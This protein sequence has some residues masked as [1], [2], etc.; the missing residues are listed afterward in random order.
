MA[1]S[2]FSYLLACLL[3][4]GCGSGSSSN[5]SVTSAAQVYPAQPLPQKF[6][7]STVMVS[8]YSNSSAKG[9]IKYVHDKA[10]LTQTR[11]LQGVNLILDWRDIEPSK[12]VFDFETIDA[13]I[14]EVKS[15]N[16]ILILRIYVNV[17]WNWQA[18][19]DWVMPDNTYLSSDPNSSN[20][21]I[22]ILPWDSKY[23][24]ALE[25]FQQQLSNHFFETKIQPDAMQITIGGLYGEQVLNDYS[26][27]SGGFNG[28]T[29][30]DKLMQA[31]YNHVDIY[32]RTLA[33]AVQDHIA[34]VNSLWPSAPVREDYVGV[35]A[36]DAG[37]S[38]IQSNA[39]ACFLESESYGP[40]TMKMLSRFKGGNAKIFLEDESGHW[41][42]PKVGKVSSL[43][44]RV[45]LMKNLQSTYNFYFD[46][47]SINADHDLDDIDGISAL[48]IMLGL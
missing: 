38:W 30:F 48:K 43:N 45:Q 14:K 10:L 17:S 31:E 20:W 2:L 36:R 34:M 13:M 22:N 9:R 42:C 29:F 37:V 16:L 19:P 41:S 21:A 44:N 7:V 47:V 24:T 12:G 4:I 25:D 26:Y 8:G 32:V 6:I 27:L 33:N 18:W 15:R 11:G 35:Y 46:A 1:K 28:T 3:L 40:D 23:Q 5:P 39:G